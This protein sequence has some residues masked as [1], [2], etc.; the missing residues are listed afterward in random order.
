[1][2]RNPDFEREG[3][4]QQTIA[5]GVGLI[6]ALAVVA[7]FHQL[8]FDSGMFPPVARAYA[9]TIE[10]G[11]DPTRAA[12]L[13]LWAIP[14]AVVQLLGGPRRQLGV[15]FGTGLLILNSTAGWVVLAGVVARVLLARRRRNE[16]ASP[17]AVVAAGFIAGDALW[18][19]GSSVVRL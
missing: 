10:T 5:A 4:K 8:Y 11:V 16:T 18:A 14:G 6:T 12:S 9:A 13:F 15:L 1:M 2:G 19:F 7:V 17:R 3:R